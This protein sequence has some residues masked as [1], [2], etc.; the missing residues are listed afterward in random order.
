MVAWKDVIDLQG[1]LVSR[2]PTELT[3]KPC[4]LENLVPERPADGT[5]GL[6]AVPEDAISPLL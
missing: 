4:G 2:D 1:L 6:V 5:C 3:A